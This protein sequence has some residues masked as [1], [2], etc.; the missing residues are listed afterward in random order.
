[1]W[2]IM[3]LPSA[4]E[5]VTYVPAVASLLLVATPSNGATIAAPYGAAMSLPS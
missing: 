5:T 1:M 3:T 2:S 4:P